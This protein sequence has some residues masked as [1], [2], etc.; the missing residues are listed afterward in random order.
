MQTGPVSGGQVTSYFDQGAKIIELA[1][2]AYSLWLRQ[3]PHEKAKLLRI[4]LSNCTFDGVSLHPTYRKPF[5]W[6]AEGLDCSNWQGL[7]DDFRN[8]FHSEECLKT[9]QLLGA[10]A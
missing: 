7:L 2:N 10:V 1:Q 3:N 8:Y 4:L 5:C 6:L 9:A